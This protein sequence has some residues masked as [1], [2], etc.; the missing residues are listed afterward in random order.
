ML[1]FLS[2]FQCLSCK[3]KTLVM[4]MA[5]FLE[6][7]THWKQWMLAFILSCS[8]CFNS[9]TSSLAQL[10]NRSPMIVASAIADKLVK[11][12]P[13]KYKISLSLP[14]G[15]FDGLQVIDFGRTYQLGKPLLAYAYTELFVDDAME[16]NLNLEHNNGCKI[17]LNGQLVYQKEENGPIKLMYE[18]RSL[19]LKHSVILKLKKGSNALLVKSTTLGKEWK[20]YFQPPS[21][22]GAILQ[23]RLSIQKLD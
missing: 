23:K 5:Q 20:C 16:F 8:F 22:K 9:P 2:S 11:E 18:E 17:W 14:N 3:V 4:Q 15:H 6:F 21:Q 12:T 19:E 13:F 7:R 1:E 10:D